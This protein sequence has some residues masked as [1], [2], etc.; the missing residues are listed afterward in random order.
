MAV[1]QKY[2]ITNAG[3]TITFDTD[4]EIPCLYLTPTGGAV[5]L[6][7]NIAVN[8]TGT[9]SDGQVVSVIW[10]AGFTLNGNT[11]TI[12]GIS[13]TALESLNDGVLFFKYID[14][15]APTWFNLYSADLRVAGILPGTVLSD[16]SLTL[17]KFPALTRG[18]IW[19]GDGTNR[20][21]LLDANGNGAIGIGDG[22]DY[23]FVVPSGDWTMNSA[24]VN[25][26]G[27]GKVTAAMIAA[28]AGI[29][30]NKLAALTAS[31][32]VRTDGSGFITTVNQVAA[33]DGGNGL[34][35]SA[36]TGFPVWNAGT[37]SVGS[38]TELI[39]LNVS[40]NTGY[41]GDFKIKM[42]F[43]GTVTEIYGYITQATVGA[44]AGTCIAKNNGGTTM[45]SGTITTTAGGDVRGTA[46]TVI[47]SANNTFIVG[48]ILTF[49]TAT[50]TA[51]EMQL[52]IKVT[53]TS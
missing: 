17:A 2:T 29:Q 8:F 52:S 34:D 1:Y 28:L 32:I 50:A 42:P 14:G 43:A 26:I 37:Q 46:Y 3:Q 20:P 4:N 41:V 7:G 36:A 12:N 24:G 27:A 9:P 40:W 11:F 45:T 19:T 22:T 21:A 18:F 51:G 39:T 47:P 23:V 6:L 30:L 31:K 48:D 10:E 35:N 33:V 5:T 49:T 44:T 16:A 38:I 13:L 53:R 15:A 25:A